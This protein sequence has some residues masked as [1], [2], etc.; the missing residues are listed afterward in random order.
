MMVPADTIAVV[1]HSDF[2]SHAV[3]VAGFPPHWPAN[4]ELLP[5]MISMDHIKLTPAERE[6]E[7]KRKA[8]KLAEHN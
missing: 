1:G 2:M 5:M 7:K 4:C 3:E 8:P 6:E